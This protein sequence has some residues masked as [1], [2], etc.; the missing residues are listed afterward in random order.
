MSGFVN[1]DFWSG[2]GVDVVFDAQQTWPFA[3]N[4]VT[5]ISSYHTLEHLKGWQIFFKEAHRV[6]IPGGSM[7]LQLPYGAS[8]DGMA[9]PGHVRFWLPT[10]FCAL[11]PNYKIAG[12]PQ[13]DDL[14]LFDVHFLGVVVN[15]KLYWL[16]WKP[17]RKLGLFLLPFLFGGYT[18]MIVGLMA[19]KTKE[20]FDLFYMRHPNRNIVA[21][22]LTEVAWLHH[23]N[24]KKWIQKGKPAEIVSLRATKAAAISYGDAIP[25]RDFYGRRHQ[26]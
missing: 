20:H 19:L 26:Q 25:M 1:C 11:Q 16:V 4:S 7:T 14:G 13:H 3:D 2:P 22:P 18:E 5:A 24:T 15:P 6:L 17:W 21:I 23:W 10:S 9:E 8:I 12:N